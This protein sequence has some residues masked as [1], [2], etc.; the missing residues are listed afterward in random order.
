MRLRAFLSCLGLLFVFSVSV[1]AQERE[2]E[3]EKAPPPA[4]HPQAARHIPAHGPAPAA[5]ARQPAAH[6]PSARPEAS[7]PTAHHVDADD[8]WIGHDSGRGDRQFHQDHPFAHGRFT[9]GFGPQ[10]VFR[11]AGGGPRH[12]VF[13]EFAFEVVPV[14]F[15]FCNDWLWDSDEIVIYEDPDH[16]GYYLAYNV[17]TGTY[18]HVLFLGTA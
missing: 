7:H 15:G 8:R 13:S 16:D 5:P 4:P 14:D 3:K 6:E 9:G 2:R 11:L 12:F 10:H 17:R 18:V 1:G